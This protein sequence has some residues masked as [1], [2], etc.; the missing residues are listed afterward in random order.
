V[1]ITVNSIGVIHSPYTR[2]ESCPIQGA[3]APN[4]KGTV[5]VFSEYADGLN[6]IETFSHI[7]LIYHFNRA[8]EIKLVRPTFLDDAAHGIFASRH[9]C[10]P[11]GLGIS[12]VR[13]L[14]RHGNV[15]EVGGIDVLDGTPLLDIKPYVPRFDCFPEAHEGWVAGKPSRP[16]PSG[17]E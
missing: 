1:S 4:G 2:K 16:K 8:G 7:M 17:R 13:L 3:E 5:E 15:L 14:S 10:R 11:S 6:D 9:P 12:I